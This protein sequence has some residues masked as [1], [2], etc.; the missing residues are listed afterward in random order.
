MQLYYFNLKDRDGIIHDPDGTELANETEAR[1]HAT[2][3]ARELM[4]SRE[5]TT[6]TWRLQVCDAA[7]QPCFELLFATLSS[8][9]FPG[10]LRNSYLSVA[11]S[12]ASLSDE[13]VDLRMTLRQI[14]GTMA[15]AEG[16]PYLAAVNGTRIAGV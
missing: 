7:R 11:G 5:R 13:I 8:V 1:A 3:V 9:G 12:F 16:G 14:R 15:R 10:E 4:Q 6:G 2:E